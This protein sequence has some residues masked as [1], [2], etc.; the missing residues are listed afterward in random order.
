MVWFVVRRVISS[1]VTLMVVATLIFVATE[2]LPGDVATAV[3]G[4]EATPKR[5]AELRAQLQLDR[6]AT[7]RYWDWLSAFVQGDWGNSLA[8]P[9]QE[10]RPLIGERL[11]NS[12][13]LSS[14]AG[15]VGIVISLVLGVFAGLYRN[16]WFDVVVSTVSLI[17]MSLP[18]FVIG[19]LLMLLFGVV[20]ALLPAVT[21]VQ[22][23]ATLGEL[24]PSMILPSLTLVIVM[25]AYILR[26]VRSSV[27]DVAHSEYV[28]MAYLKGVPHRRVVWRHIIPNALI[29]SINA[30]ALTIA[31]LI[32]G[33]V[34]VESVFN[35]PG[36][37]RLLSSA[38][39]DR[40]LPLVQ[41]LGLVGAVI[42]IGINICADIATLW[43]TPRL[44]T[45]YWRT[46]DE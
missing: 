19:S 2:V 44:R 25:V 36:I 8:R 31:W 43:L 15:I 11:R 40:D 14:I 5:L 17:G 27:I 22:P 9:Q 38:V 16:R 46:A 32:G 35:F 26:M 23:Q 29:P 42:Y 28:Q 21:I 20:W 24:I 34:V 10:I 45:Q 37:G 6:P 41:A 4:R 12:L 1:L 18:E 3:L 30:V 13:W 7:E 33:I 39:S